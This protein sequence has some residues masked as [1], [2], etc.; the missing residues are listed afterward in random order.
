MMLW[1]DSTSYLP[2]RLR[3]VEPNGDTT[4]YRFLDMRINEGI[5]R[6]RFDLVLPQ[7]IEV[8]SVE[9]GS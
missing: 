3:Y 1:I 4:E 9:L 8:R 6:D 5:A 7:D 2:M